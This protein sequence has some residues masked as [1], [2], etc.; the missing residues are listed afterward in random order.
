[1]K[2]V[3][4]LGLLTAAVAACLWLLGACFGDIEVPPAPADSGAGA[5]GSAPPADSGSDAGVDAVDG[6]AADTAAAADAQDAAPVDASSADAAV[7]AGP[8]PPPPSCA[9]IGLG[10]TNCGSGESCCTSLPVTGGTFSRTYTSTDAGPTGAANPATVSRYRLDKYAVTVGRFREFVAAWMG[11][12]NPPAGSGKHT[13]LNAGQ[14]LVNCESAASAYETGWVATDDPNIAP[15]TA[16]LG[17][18]TWTGAPVSN[19]SLP[20]TMVNWYEA[21]AFCIWDGGFLPSEAEGEYAAAGGA[22]ELEYPWGSTDPGTGNQYAIYQ[23]LYPSGMMNACN[24]PADDYIA[25]VGTATLGVGHWGQMDLAGN[26]FEWTLDYSASYVACD[27]CA[28]LSPTPDP[29][30]TMRSQKGGT[31]A[32]PRTVLTPP[33]RSAEPPATR[34]LGFGIRCARTP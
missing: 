34:G 23:C 11:G 30:G 8:P 14:G 27:D 15:T 32:T 17:T 25:P 1:M 18:G 21:Y 29:N 19:E 7:D 4:S 20:I 12:W 2:R 22:L 10:R 26:A 33:Y 31:F 5:D 24:G 28:A 3:R 6:T 16:N 9:V 13:H